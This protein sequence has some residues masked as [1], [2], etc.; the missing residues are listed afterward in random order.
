[1]VNKVNISHEDISTYV[2]SFS[3]PHIY[4]EL[5]LRAATIVI[6]FIVILLGTIGNSFVILFFLLKRSNLKPFEMFMISLGL[7]DFINSAVV[8][9]HCLLEL[10]NFNFYYIGNNG[11]KVLSFLSITCMTVA[12]LT[13]TAV[14]INRFIAVKWPLKTR[15]YQNRLILLIIACTW[16]FASGLGSVYL[17]DGNICLVSYNV[18]LKNST[19][20]V[21]KCYTCM[22]QNKYIVFVL[23]MFLMQTGIPLIVMIILYTLIV[24]ELRKNFTLLMST[25]NTLKTCLMKNKKT[26][27]LVITVVLVFSICFFPVNI[28]FLWYMFSHF[29]PSE[30]IEISYDILTMLQM[31]NSIANPIIYSRFHTTFRKCIVKLILPCINHKK[32]KMKKNYKRKHCKKIDKQ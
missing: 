26:T 13:L 4:K 16:F 25:R 23:T 12:P 31:C 14:S 8:P 28:F 30:K 9:S 27:K 24:I 21:F 5:G 22:E 2:P 7:T 3:H 17:I 29:T 1:M 19:H 20:N 18:T 10:F 6:S 11:C 15:L 32:I